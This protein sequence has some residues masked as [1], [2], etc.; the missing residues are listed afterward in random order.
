MRSLASDTARASRYSPAYL[1]SFSNTP[2][3]FAF[4]ALTHAVARV[5]WTSSSQR[6]GSAPASGFGGGAF[7]ACAPRPRDAAT[8]EI[9]R[10]VK[11]NDRV[12][13]M[14][15]GTGDCDDSAPRHWTRVRGIVKA[16]P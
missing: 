13:I 12:V 1:R 11:R 4:S 5:P 8:A 7:D 6:Y 14:V 16:H 15:S 2:S 9:K 10:I 3:V